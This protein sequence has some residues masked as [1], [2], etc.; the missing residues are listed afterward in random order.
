M[1]PVGLMVLT[2]LTWPAMRRLASGQAASKVAYGLPPLIALCMG[3]TFVQI[4][5]PQ[6]DGRIQRNAETAAADCAG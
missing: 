2:L 1:L 6:S 5:R 4:F 3:A